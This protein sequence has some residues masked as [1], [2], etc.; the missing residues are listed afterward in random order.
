[1]RYPAVIRAIRQ[2]PVPSMGVALLL[3]AAAVVLRRISPV[4]LS[5]VT[6]YPAIVVATIAGGWVI[7]TATLL[8]ATLCAIYFFI[9]PVGSFSLR[10]TDAWNVLAFWVVCLIIISLI[11]LLV[12][13]LISTD[14][15]NH[16][17]AESD[18]QRRTLLR[19]LTHRMKNQYAVILAMAR[20]T[21]RHATTIAE[22]EDVFA[23]RLHGMSRAHDLLTQ[24]DW[25]SVSLRSLIKSE[26]DLFVAPDRVE[27]VGV[28][29]RVGEAVVVNLGLALHE[30]A[31][32]SA[33]YG[34][35]ANRAGKVV[36]R[37]QLTELQFELSWT[38]QDGMAPT[39]SAPKGFGTTIL[40]KIVPYA[41]HGSSELTFAAEGFRYKLTLPASTVSCDDMNAA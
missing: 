39:D 14:D 41:L 26:V 2:R 11:Q 32:N 23:E 25:T 22:F 13:L 31:T 29:C 9:P 38:E 10:Y 17:L 18:D 40:A 8:V 7:G 33:K 20:A 6:F 21:G 3:V 34:A 35:W 19:E 16:R 15:L 1:M 5:Y 30:L 36:I 28:E 12:K 4:T 27:M 24:A 37:W